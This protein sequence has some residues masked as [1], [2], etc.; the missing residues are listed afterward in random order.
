MDLKF[1]LDHLDV[2]SNSYT[3]SVL[4]KKTVTPMLTTSDCLPD[5]KAAT[6]SLIKKMKVSQAM[7]NAMERNRRLSSVKCHARCCVPLF[8]GTAA[9]DGN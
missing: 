8:D 4:L 3:G 5:A 1:C 9:E 7:E 6:K 2:F